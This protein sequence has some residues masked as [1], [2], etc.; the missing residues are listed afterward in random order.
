MGPNVVSIVPPPWWTKKII[1]AAWCSKKYSIEARG[2][3]TFMAEVWLAISR[4]MPR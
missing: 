4:A 2:A 3:V 1:V